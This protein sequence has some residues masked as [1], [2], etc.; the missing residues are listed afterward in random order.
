MVKKLPSLEIQ[1]DETE[2]N[3]EVDVES[4][5]VNRYE[6]SP[7]FEYYVLYLPEIPEG[8]GLRS[9]CELLVFYREEEESTEINGREIWFKEPWPM[10][11]AIFEKD[12]ENSIEE[13][14]DAINWIRTREIG[15]IDNASLHVYL[16]DKMGEYTLEEV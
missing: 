12:I 1:L 7:D 4:L 16:S 15:I 2:E 6:R 8:R 10:I 3:I 5:E 9:V 11:F 14:A 13:L